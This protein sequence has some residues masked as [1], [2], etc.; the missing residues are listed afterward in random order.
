MAIAAAALA[1]L[2]ATVSPSQADPVIGGSP[3]RLLVTGKQS[4][5]EFALFETTGD[6]I[7]IVGP[8]LTVDD[9]VQ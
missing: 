2:A 3:E 7:D 6:G 5:G 8:G 9:Y 1:V 4:G